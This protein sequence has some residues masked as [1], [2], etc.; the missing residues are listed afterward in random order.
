MTTSASEGRRYQSW[1]LEPTQSRPWGVELAAAQAFPLFKGMR[2]GVDAFTVFAA[3]ARSHRTR[4]I[5]RDYR[6]TGPLRP[7][8]TEP[9]TR[10]PTTPRDSVLSRLR[11]P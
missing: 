1:P 2:S 6:S 3:S 10:N 4:P 9:R 11:G 8:H 7:N 5:V